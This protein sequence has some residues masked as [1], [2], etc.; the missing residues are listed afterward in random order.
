MEDSID[1]AINSPSP[2]HDS[3]LE[4][5]KKKRKT[6]KPSYSS[7]SSEE[8]EKATI[9]RT[10]LIYY[11]THYPG[12]ELTRTGKIQ[13]EVGEMTDKEVIKRLRAM[14]AELQAGVVGLNATGFLSGLGMALDRMFGVIGLS[15]KFLADPK[16][17]SL[18]DYYVPSELS[19]LSVPCQML[20]K[21]TSH[22]FDL[23]MNPSIKY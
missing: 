3:E 1:E 2:A 5:P 22:I 21:I 23:K 18:A 10:E 9:A 12:L 15:D 20:H 4:P 11:M 17:V 16:L 6:S 19:W 14:K 13:E 8:D 7:S